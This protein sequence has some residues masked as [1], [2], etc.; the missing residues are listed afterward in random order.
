MANDG[1]ITIGTKIDQ[2]GAKH[3]VKDLQKTLQGSAKKA[4]NV[5]KKMSTYL[6]API[7]AVG[8]AGFAAADS[9]DQAYRNIRVGTGAT[10][11]KLE[12]LKDTFKDVFESVPDS[13]DQ[14]SNAL[15][16]INTLTGATGDQLGDL[17]K[18]VLDASRTLGEDGVANSEA[19]GRAM[20]QWQIPA[21]EGVGQLDHLYKMT[22]DYGVGLGELSGQLTTYGSVL[23]NAGF[24]MQE[25]A[26]FMA[27]LE[28]NGI[29]V[30]RIMPGLNKSFRDWASE[31]KNSRDEL[32]KVVKKIRETE[33]SQEALSL[34][35]ETFGAEGAQR[36]MTAIKNGAIPAF[37][38]LGDSMEG[39]QGLINETTEETKTIGEQFQELKNQSMTALEP[40][41]QTL[42]NL[43][44]DALPPL[45]SAVQKVA[46][47]FANLSP[48]AQIVIMVVGAIIA[49]IGP[50]LILL[51]SLSLVVMGLSAPFLMWT[52]IIVGVI[53]IVAVLATVIVKNW[54]KIQE[55][56]VQIFV[57]VAAFL[58]K[59]WQDFWDVTLKFIAL[60][61]AKIAS[62]WKSAS[63]LTKSVFSGIASF[64]SSIFSKIGSI[65]TKSVEFCQSIIGKAW[66]WVS[67]TTSSI[68]S[69]I[70]GFFSRTWS[71]LLSGISSLK[72]GFV[73]AWVAIKNG[74]KR[75]IN[76]IISMANGVLRAIESM[77]NG[78][79]RAINGI[80]S[81]DIPDWVPGIGGGSFGLPHIPSV[82]L[83][84]I[85]SLATGG[86]AADPTLAM[87]GDAG[88]GN[89]EIV[90]PE[91]M[92]RN[93]F[94]SEMQRNSGGGSIDIGA[95]VDKVLDKI[96]LETSFDVNG[97]AIVR[98]TG[99]PMKRYLQGEK[100]KSARGRGYR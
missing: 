66:R 51:S 23:G 44:K 63:N 39:S 78:I 46:E 81:I 91:K 61:V 25:S 83:P 90:A 72:D 94:S 79:S 52:G 43:A 31:G 86:V 80:P 10:G 26:E 15:S 17:T 40:L 74:V 30:S 56:T 73:S 36:L 1:K 60:V 48:T 93:I 45:I 85:P 76:G 100:V 68:W 12:G 3:G 16:T 54:S 96:V 87:I 89:P 37:D 11:D 88:T 84:R 49:A 4:N 6:T 55:F 64:F 41:G 8:A 59:F 77:V 20:K 69:G 28:S 50:L 21:D 95:L 7:M 34:A 9:L 22:Q 65:F 32:E 98:T 53:A 42:L 62:G 58:K 14:V 33:D 47:W 75:P 24:N 13:A 35:T 5:G 29:A 18:G 38:E 71:K 99:K 19:F 97:E 70:S 67:D 57:A 82:S 27:S 92:L 2:L